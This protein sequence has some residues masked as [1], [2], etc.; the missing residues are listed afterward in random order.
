MQNNNID[1]NVIHVLI[2]LHLFTEMFFSR[3][4]RYCNTVKA[5][6]LHVHDFLSVISTFKKKDTKA[7]NKHLVIV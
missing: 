4:S 5:N 7:I 1:I 6:V 2:I 3:N